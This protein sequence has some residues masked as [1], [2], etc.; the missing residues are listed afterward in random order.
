MTYPYK[1]LEE[2]LE[3]EFKDKNLLEKAF[4]HRSYLNECMVK[5]ED[6]ESYERLEFL[7]DA[8]LELTVS[9]HIYRSFEG[10]SEGA[11]T[12]MRSNLVCEK[13]LST[14][15]REL[16][17]GNYLFLG[18]GELMSNGRE[19]DS[20]LC[21]VFESVLGAVYIDGGFEPAANIVRRFLIPRFSEFMV[22]NYKSL[23]QEKVQSYNPRARISYG[24]LEE[25]GPPHKRTFKMGIFVDDN[26]MGIGIGKT[27]KDAEQLAARAALEG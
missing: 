27:K 6:V 23:Y 4:V 25:I 1:E 2:A 20:I 8:V 14:I 22:K 16:G 26:L 11:L 13:S 15:S 7:G 17:L 3:Y 24:V 10:K 21:D 5:S 12:A 18:K 19:K 9:D